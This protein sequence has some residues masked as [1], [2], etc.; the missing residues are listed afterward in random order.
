MLVDDKSQTAEAEKAVLSEKLDAP[1]ALQR[2]YLDDDNAELLLVKRL[3]ERRGHKVTRFAE[4]REA[5][6][7]LQKALNFFIL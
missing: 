6:A 4:P 7:A 5:L 2:L 1:T 3:L